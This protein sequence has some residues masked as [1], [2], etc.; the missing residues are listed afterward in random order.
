[1]K[2]Y[3]ALLLAGMMAFS[4]AAC[5]G[6]SSAPAAE[7]VIPEA[8]QPMQTVVTYHPEESVTKQLPV[9]A[10]R[11]LPTVPEAS[12]ESALQVADIATVPTVS[13]A[14]AAPVAPAPAA[15]A[16]KEAPKAPVAP[17]AAA[18]AVLYPPCS[19]NRSNQE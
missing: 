11:P 13:A 1:M 6:S 19:A 3:F 10:L 7:P 2:K 9:D 12:V 16:V 4:L 15:P 8:P 5:G 17:A 18:N 14:P